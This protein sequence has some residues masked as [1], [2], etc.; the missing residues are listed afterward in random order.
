MERNTSMWVLL[1]G[2]GLHEKCP[3]WWQRLPNSCGGWNLLLH[4]EKKGMA[5][6]KITPSSL[7]RITG[8]RK[9]HTSDAIYYP[10]LFIHRPKFRVCWEQKGLCIDV[11]FNTT[12]STPWPIWHPAEVYLGLISYIYSPAQLSVTSCLMNNGE[13]VGDPK[14]KYGNR[15]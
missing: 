3:G 6:F 4:P 1:L 14:R 13:T 9:K 7:Q 8:P 5:S 2:W 11:L 15:G 12:L 10:C